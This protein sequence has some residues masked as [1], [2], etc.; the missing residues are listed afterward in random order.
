MK[1]KIGEGKSCSAGSTQHSSS[2]PAGRGAIRKAKKHSLFPSFSRK[3]RRGQNAIRYDSM[4]GKYQTEITSSE[5][6]RC[7]VF[8]LEIS[9]SKQLNGLTLTPAEFDKIFHGQPSQDWHKKNN[10]TGSEYQQ[11]FLDEQLALIL[12]LWGRQHGKT[13][14][15]GVVVE[16]MCAFTLPLPELEGK[17]AV[18]ETGSVEKVWIHNDNV[19][20]LQNKPCN[21]FSGITILSPSTSTEAGK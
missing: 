4:V 19:Q 5:G 20:A 16:E 17:S 18:P 6:M 7:G 15:L 12:Y 2:K 9:T 1:V 11:E 3:S 8:S 21:H 14:Q 13:L 10:L